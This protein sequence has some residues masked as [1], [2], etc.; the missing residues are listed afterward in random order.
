MVRIGRV[1]YLNTLPLFYLWEA[2]GVSFVEDHPSELVKLLRR[3]QLEAGIVSSLEYLNHPEDYRLVR[4]LSI[5]SAKRACSVLILSSK[6]L[7]KVNSVYLSPAS[8]T[9]RA[10]ALYLIRRVYKREPEWLE[11]RGRAEALMLIGDE[12]IEERL[13]GKWQYVYDLGEEWFRLYGLPFVFA[14]FLVRKD[15]P[16]GLEFL[17]EE[18]CKKSRNRFFKDLSEGKLKVEGYADPFL[19]EYFTS[20]LNYDLDERGEESLKI[21]KRILIREGLVL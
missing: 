1:R 2:P 3:G 16:E 17:I 8:L 15:A 14:L 5:S 4:G 7:E 20:C 18:Q 21:F 11:E 9:S 12:A 19:T 10:L 6:P 13:R